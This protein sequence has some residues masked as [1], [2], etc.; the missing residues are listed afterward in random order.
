MD[1]CYGKDG[2][3][4]R[5]L[6]PNGQSAQTFLSISCL[7]AL[8]RSGILRDVGAVQDQRA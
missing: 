7:G 5:P 4:V 6:S 2:A 3:L 1:Q 8:F